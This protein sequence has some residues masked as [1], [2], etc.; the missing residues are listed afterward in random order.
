MNS[1]ANVLNLD[2]SEQDLNSAGQDYYSSHKD[3]DG[4]YANSEIVEIGSLTY[5]C[6]TF[7]KFGDYSNHIDIPV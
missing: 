3:V 6:D 4:C 5:S 1:V 2:I 7:T